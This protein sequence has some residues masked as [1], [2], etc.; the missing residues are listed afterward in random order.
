MHLAH[1]L[2]PILGL[3]ILTNLVKSQI[4]NVAS[5][6][7]HKFSKFQLK[8]ANLQSY[9]FSSYDQYIQHL[10]QYGMLGFPTRQESAPSSGSHR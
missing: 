3:L 8:V 10:L 4:H 2:G 7:S 5:V 1:L 6:Q 9:K